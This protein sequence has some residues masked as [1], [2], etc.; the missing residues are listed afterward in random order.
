L[1]N[2]IALSRQLARPHVQGA[3]AAGRKAHSCAGEQTR[4]GSNQVGRLGSTTAGRRK[5]LT[6]RLGFDA[7]GEASTGTGV[8]R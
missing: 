4:T 3:R 7:E 2:L 5:V 8:R 1:T 6:R